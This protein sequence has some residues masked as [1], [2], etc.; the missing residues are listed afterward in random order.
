MSIWRSANSRLSAASDCATDSKS[1]RIGILADANVDLAKTIPANGELTA[2][3]A[4]TWPQILTSEE[5]P[6]GES[7]HLPLPNIPSR[8]LGRTSAISA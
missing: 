8:L 3:L 1:R 4:V 7:G 5:P 2:F 6:P